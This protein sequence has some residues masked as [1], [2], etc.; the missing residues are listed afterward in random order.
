LLSV[1]NNFSS[2]VA[3]YTGDSLTNLTLVKMDTTTMFGR[4]LTFQAQ[5]GVTY[6]FAIDG[7]S[8]FGDVEIYGRPDGIP[9]INQVVRSGDELILTVR[10][11]PGRMHRI[12]ESA[13]LKSWD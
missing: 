3:I 7:I 12:D 11:L 4:Y 9:A 1:S 13:D 6:A 10:G 8:R 5:A 2:A